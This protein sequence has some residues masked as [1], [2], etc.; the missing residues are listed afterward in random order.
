MNSPKNSQRFPPVLPQK[1]PALKSGHSISPKKE[2]KKRPGVKIPV[3]LSST[4]VEISYF[5]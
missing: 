1:P 5:V 3:L 4:A 2:T